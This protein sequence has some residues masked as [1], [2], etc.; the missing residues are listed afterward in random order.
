VRKL[1]LFLF[2]F[3]CST[4]FADG[5][6]EKYFMLR[7]KVTDAKNNELLAGVKVSVN[8][9]TLTTYSD[10]DGNFILFIPVGSNNIIYFEMLSYEPINYL[11]DSKIGSE[12]HISLQG[13]PN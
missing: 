2:F 11:I 5:P 1:T 3:I 12:L 8:G 7:G 6:G 4:V 10:F 9:Q 13:R